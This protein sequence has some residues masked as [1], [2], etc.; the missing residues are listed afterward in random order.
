MVSPL[1]YV[2]GCL[3]WEKSDLA[4]DFQGKPPEKWRCLGVSQYW[5]D[6]GRTLF[7]IIVLIVSTM[8]RQFGYLSH[9]LMHTTASGSSC[10]GEWEHPRG[11]AI[12]I[13]LLDRNKLRAPR[14]KVWLWWN[15]LPINRECRVLEPGGDHTPIWTTPDALDELIWYVK[16]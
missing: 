3:I 8:K 7:C 10:C 6:V 15:I 16:I 5:Y 4:M 14:H 12:M 13:K 1:K 11:R 9:P 2:G